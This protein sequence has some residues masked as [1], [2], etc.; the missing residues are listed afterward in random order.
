MSFLYKH[1]QIGTIILVLLA[2]LLPLVFFYLS[3][4][5]LGV[6]A[7]VLIGILVLT[8]L[9]STLTVTITAERIK[10]SFGVGLIHKSFPLSS[11]TNTV[12]VKNP[13]Y[14]GW[15]IRLTPRGWMFNISGLDAVEIELNSQSY[16]RIG[17]D[18]PQALKSAIDE[19]IEVHRQLG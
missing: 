6:G 11:I 13:W 7:S 10:C 16:F 14:Y 19:A 15:G 4:G 18:E 8:I 9:L 12:I 3:K 1:T 5:F 17:T 2:A